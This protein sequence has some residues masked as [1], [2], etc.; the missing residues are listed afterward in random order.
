MTAEEELIEQL[1]TLLAGHELGG[2]EI[3]FCERVIDEGFT[4]PYPWWHNPTQ[5]EIEDAQ[6]EHGSDRARAQQIIIAHYFPPS[7]P[8][9]ARDAQGREAKA[10]EVTS[11]QTDTAASPRGAQREG[12]AS[13][14]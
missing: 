12:E 2:A 9:R 10:G 8:P 5:R 7:G 6:E 4:G 1:K 14:G 13:Q 3:E 11:E